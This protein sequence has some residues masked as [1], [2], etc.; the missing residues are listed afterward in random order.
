MIDISEFM[1]LPKFAGYS[2][3]DFCEWM[4]DNV[5]MAAV[6]GSSFFNEEVNNLI[7][8]HFAREIPVLE[9]VISRLMKMK[10]LAFA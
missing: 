10:E 3:Q 4:I 9:E 7:R 2:D 1:A 5:G 6:P 8:L